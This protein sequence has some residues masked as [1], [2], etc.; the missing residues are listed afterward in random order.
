MFASIGGN[1]G[2]SE[3]VLRRPRAR[4]RN[5]KFLA[6][7]RGRWALDVSTH[8]LPNGRVSAFGSYAAAESLSPAGVSQLTIH[9]MPNLSVSIPNASAQYVFSSGIVTSPPCERLSK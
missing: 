1:T 6:V 2:V 9:L 8:T 4:C 5:S 3:C 7:H